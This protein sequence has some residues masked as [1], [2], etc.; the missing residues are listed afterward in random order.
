MAKTK[1]KSGESCEALPISK[2]KLEACRNPLGAKRTFGLKLSNGSHNPVA[3][4]GTSLLSLFVAFFYHP[5][6]S[7]YMY[8]CALTEGLPCNGNARKN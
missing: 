2:I 4:A 7:L 5:L 1:E 3:T 8:V 6:P